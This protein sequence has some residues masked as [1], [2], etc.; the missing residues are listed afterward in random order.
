[1]TASRLSSTAASG[2]NAV[3]VEA[4]RCAGRTIAICLREARERLA[5]AGIES[6]ALEARIL[7]AHVLQCDQTRLLARPEEVPTPEAAR[8]FFHLLARR[9]QGEPLAY[10]LGRR[11]F[12]TLDLQVGPDC[13]IPRF[14]TEVLVEAA[15]ARLPQGVAR[16]LDLG[17][18]SGAVILALKSERPEIEAWG[19]DRSG[20]ALAI[21]RA[22]GQTHGLAVH[23][24][25]GEWMDALGTGFRFDLI[26]ANP[27][28]IA[29]QDPC[30]TVGD[31]RFE[32]EG[33]LVAGHDGLDDLRRIAAE[34][35][36]HLAVGGWLLL[37]HGWTQGAAVR[38]LMEK[39]G[40]SS[41]ST[42][43]DLAGRPRVTEGCWQPT[44][45]I[46]RQALP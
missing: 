15:L 3:G 21:A 38:A 43:A 17:T 33:A 16:V 9:E 31:L 25:V 13:L 34:A 8:N 2:H 39:N 41:V 36:A 30:L 40:F 5:A 12:W 46:S 4:V 6:A 7:F 11:E 35:V 22:N 42:L 45:K 27:P 28:Y 37:E 19:V 24:F 1:M 14:E 29:E 23:W 32:P 18:G 26:V 44:G 20:Q 10:L